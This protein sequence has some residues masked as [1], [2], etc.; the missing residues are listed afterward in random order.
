ML[1]QLTADCV[2]V[3][4]P[5]FFGLGQVETAL[6]FDYKSIAEKHVTNKFHSA[7]AYATSLLVVHIPFSFI[8]LIF[9]FKC[10]WPPG[11]VSPPPPPPLH[12]LALNGLLSVP[13]MC[14]LPLRCCFLNPTSLSCLPPRTPLPP[15]PTHLCFL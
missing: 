11:A 2:C 7:L 12:G 15:P 10:V 4:P 5:P 1:F 3:Y 8:V 6:A 13:L 9:F 14:G